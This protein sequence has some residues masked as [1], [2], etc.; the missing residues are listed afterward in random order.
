M[1][2]QK[3]TDNKKLHSK[4]M[5]QKKNKKQ[6]QKEKNQIR[7]RELNKL[8]GQMLRNDSEG[9]VWDNWPLECLT[10]GAG[11]LSKNGDIFYE[12]FV[13]FLT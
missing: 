9:E 4:L 7:L 2:K 8:A 6:L 1:A 5:D 12:Y 11:N 13:H 10:L 3:N